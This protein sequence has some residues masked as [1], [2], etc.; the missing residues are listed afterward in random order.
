MDMKVMLGI[1]IGLS[2]VLLVGLLYKRFR[3]SNNR[4]VPTLPCPT[5]LGQTRPNISLP[6]WGPE[7]GD[8]YTFSNFKADVQLWQIVTDTAPH[9]QAATIV[10]NLSLIH[11]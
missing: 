3:G 6:T 11:I 2:M 10:K 4:E 8:N 9:R 5:R 1:V 7:M